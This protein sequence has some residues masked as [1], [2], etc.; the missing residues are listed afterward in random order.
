MHAIEAG[1]HASTVALLVERGCTLRAR[2]EH[3]NT[4]MHLLGRH[5]NKWLINRLIEAGLSLEDRNSEG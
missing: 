5:P 2:D 1:P 4:L 3:G